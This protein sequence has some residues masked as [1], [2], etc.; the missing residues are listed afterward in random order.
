MKPLKLFLIYTLLLPCILFTNSCSSAGHS[1]SDI[2]FVGSTPGD[3]LIKSLL[4]IH[5]ETKV[6][7]IRWDL[8]LT[9]TK[10]NQNTFVLNIAFG[11]A[12][13]NTL[14]FKE[15]G[16]RLSFKGEFC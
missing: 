4:T 16:K 1:S 8:T 11:E 14:G 6:D 3:E 10:F 2:V 5:P 7:F 9:N 12:Q 13:P 15:G